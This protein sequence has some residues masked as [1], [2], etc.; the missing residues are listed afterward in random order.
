MK[1]K[2]LSLVDHST[3]ELAAGSC[4]VGPFAHPAPDPDTGE[5]LEELMGPSPQIQRVYRLVEQVAPTNLTV[6]IHGETGAGK[7]LVARAI[8]KANSR[9][10]KRFV[11]LDC[12]SIPDT[13]IESELFGHERGAFTGAEHRREGYFELANG[14]TLFLDEIANL[15]PAMMR[16]LLCALEDRRIYR[17]GG[18]EPIEIDIRV[19]A[20]SN[21]NL[22]RL[23]GQGAF[24]SDL[25]H[26]L[27]EF[28]I[29][30]PPLRQR[31]DD[32][33]YLAQRFVGQANEQFGKTAR[34]LSPG[35]REVLFAYGWPGNV[36][37]LRN[38][39]RRAV[40]LCDDTI[41]PRHLE[42]A[43]ATAVPRAPLA[44]EPVDMDVA[45]LCEGQWSLRDITR[46]CVRRTEHRVLTA[47]LERT[48][49][50]KSQAARLLNCDYKTLYYKARAIGY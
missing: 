42:C 34:G 7:S 26:R 41:E 25:Y 47:I 28:V 38:V 31:R 16:K 6:L 19:V 17:V 18:R 32:I 49:G 43:N 35:A 36:R 39:I 11:R 23:V 8:H 9:A 1:G 24:R 44:E 48:G 4:A 37:E 13:L 5:G 21:Q 46:E 2:A 15:S 12:G 14:G 33:P 22:D 50:N 30:V 10:S 20:A 27:N 3:P 29:E 40:V 45:L